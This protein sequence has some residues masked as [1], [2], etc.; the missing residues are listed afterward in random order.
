M[1]DEGR[2]LFRQ[3]ALRHRADRLQGSVSIATPIAWQTLG[4]L[5]LTALIAVGTFLFLGRYARVE[6]VAGV[7]AL[8]QGVASVVPSR[9]GTVVKVDVAEGQKV[10][11]GQPLL[12]VRSAEAMLD[13]NTAPERVLRAV[14]RQDDALSQQNVMASRATQAD[15]ARLRETKLGAERELVSLEVQKS[16][17]KRLIAT[18]L[19]DF[20]NARQIAASGFVSKR[21]VDLREATLL[22]RRQ[23]L[24]QLE[25]LCSAKRAEAAEAERSIAQADAN[26]KAQVA[27]TQSNRAALQQQIA[28]A[29]LA[30]GYTVTAPVGGTVTALVARVGQPAA[31]DQQVMMILPTAARPSVDIYVPTAAIG[32]VRPG[33]SVRLAVDAFPYQNFGTIAGRVE[34]VAT[35]AVART[36]P[37]G[38]VPVYI[39]RAR[40][41]QPS[42]LAYGRPHPLLPGMTLTA[43]IVTERRS[44]FEWL[45]EPVF[46]IRR[47]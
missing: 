3:E 36:G 42:I 22:T 20:D 2:Q 44:L 24:A 29:D 14:G 23:Q 16:D 27:S 18:A 4:Y 38:P 1:R 46:A 6:T 7:V 30:K 31:A 25:Q 5:L 33:Q 12:S 17:Q 37:S 39:V 9:A 40:V 47:R 45:F 19:A 41:P 26:L 10:R 15:K 35:A 13:G 11:A 34:K 21:D 32:F 8:D 28:Q 43:R